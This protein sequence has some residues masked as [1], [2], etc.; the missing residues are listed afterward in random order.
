MRALVATDPLATKKEHA[1]DED[2]ATS[3][4]ILQEMAEENEDDL[5]TKDLLVSL[6]LRSAGVGVVL[7][8]MQTL[9]P[10]LGGIVSA[11]EAIQS[12]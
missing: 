2:V 12:F 11:V 8:F 3:I 4:G 1:T 7:G 5:L 10:P 9:W 6:A